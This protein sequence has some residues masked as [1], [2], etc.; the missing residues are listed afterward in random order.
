VLSGVA[1]E[2]AFGAAVLAWVRFV[3]H[4]PFAALGLPREPRKDVGTGLVGGVVLIVTGWVALVIVLVSATAILGHR[5][6]QPDQVPECVR[7]VWLWLLGPIVVVA[8][9][10]CEE[11]LFRG[12]LYQGLRSK[13]SIWPAALSSGVVFGLVHG[14]WLLIPALFVVGVG[15][16]LIYE[17][18]GSLLASM[19]AHATF[20]LF[21][22]LLIVLS[23]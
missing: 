8:A 18:R 11:T 5:P 22:F 21:G 19:T 17:R 12:F 3:S 1:S 10:L 6:A 14:Y 16:A 13:L 23:R 20:N 15:L 9:P 4:A 7:G 2:L